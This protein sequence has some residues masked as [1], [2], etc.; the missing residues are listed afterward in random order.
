MSEEANGQERQ[1]SEVSLPPGQ[2]V[3]W[4]SCVGLFLELAIIRWVS[5]EV[6]VFAFCKNLALVACFLGFGVG[7]FLWK[8]RVSIARSQ[9]LLLLF[10]LVV[11]LPWRPLRLYGPQEVSTVMARMPSMMVWQTAAPEVAWTD[12]LGTVFAVG[13][14]TLLFFVIALI[15]LP[16]GQLTAGGMNQIRPV[17][18]GYSVNVAGSLTGI[19]LYT[20]TCVAWLSPFWWFGGAALAAVW[21]GWRHG[22]RQLLLGLAVALGLV[23]MPNNSPQQQTTWSNY[24]KLTLADHRHIWVNNVGYQDMWHMPLEK[25]PEIVERFNMPYH[26]R[27]PPGKVLIVGAGSGNDA[28]AA[29]V[30]GAKE[31]TAVEIDEA[32]YRIGQRYHPNQPYRDP[33][34]LVVLDDARHFLKTTKEKYD[35]IVFSHLDS[36]TVLS[37][38]TNVRLDNYIYTVESF[39]EARSRLAPGGLL[40]VSFY[41][42]QPFIGPRL[43]RN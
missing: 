25:D 28:S 6:R 2:L 15:M 32:I 3:F 17:L 42:E 10:A 29:L 30:A 11:V 31:V 22:E 34:V 26:L 16:Y 39:Q 5:S 35:V 19:L 8:K 36:H 38:F 40:Y 14:T 37:S 41:S 4:A 24:Q 43:Y 20:L 7:C 21:L 13:W 1:E 18:R 9:L 27:K 33:R 12:F 23:F